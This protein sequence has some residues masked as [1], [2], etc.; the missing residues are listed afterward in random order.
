MEAYHKPKEKSAWIAEALEDLLGR[1]TY[2]T[3]NWSE[4]Y[5]AKEVFR[6]MLSLNER[7][8]TPSRMSSSCLQV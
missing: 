5:E 3:A 7:M 2:K 1:E 6:A 4:P 8:K